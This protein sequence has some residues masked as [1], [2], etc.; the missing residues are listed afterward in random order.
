MMLLN[1]GLLGAVPQIYRMCP[2]KSWPEIKDRKDPE[3]WR[4]PCS[5]R[6]QG[7][8][9]YREMRR[10][11]AQEENSAREGDVDSDFLNLWGGIMAM[12]LAV[13]QKEAEL[14]G[15][16][17]LQQRMKMTVLL[18]AHHKKSNDTSTSFLMRQQPAGPWAK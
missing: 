5:R 8:C 10:K 14:E 16:G 3:Q 2:K 11:K 13:D 12:K 17:G 15:T 6:V 7:A 1:I 18:A 4:A 9:R